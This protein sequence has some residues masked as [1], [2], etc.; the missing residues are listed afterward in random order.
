VISPLDAR[1]RGELAGY[2]ELASEE[3]FMRYRARV[4]LLYL[5]FLVDKL[6]G[7]GL[8]KPIDDEGRARLSLRLRLVM[9]LR[10][11]SMCLGISLR[12]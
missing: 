1:Y 8:V 11:L 4:E 12:P 2:H 5:G 7:M 6:S 10:R 3:A 9:T